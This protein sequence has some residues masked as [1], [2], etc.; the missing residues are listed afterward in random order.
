MKQNIVAQF[1]QLLK[2]WLYNVWLG[3]VMEKNWVLSVALA[4][5]VAVFD[6]SHQSAEHTSHM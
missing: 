3:V 5:G 1:I 6:A 4:A 2:P